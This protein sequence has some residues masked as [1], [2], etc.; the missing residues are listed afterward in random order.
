MRGDIT[1]ILRIAGTFAAVLVT[2]GVAFATGSTAA[3][4][5][6]LRIAD[7]GPLTLR[8]TSFRPGDRVR[9]TVHTGPATYVRLTRAGRLGRFTVRFAGVRL[10]FCATP[11][12]IT[13]RGARSGV[14]RAH[15]PIR[16]CAAP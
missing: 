7:D 13:A 16:E 15:I 14:A 5:P 4:R 9:V 3:T 2:A 8:G 1:V 11:L 10:N 12:T 6:V